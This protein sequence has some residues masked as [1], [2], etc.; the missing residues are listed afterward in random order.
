MPKASEILSRF[1]R[2][3]RKPHYRIV[4]ADTVEEM[5]SKVNNLIEFGFE[6]SGGLCVFDGC[7][8]QVMIFHH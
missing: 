3:Q 2:D 6:P 8:S 5:C 4:V 1:L 7:L